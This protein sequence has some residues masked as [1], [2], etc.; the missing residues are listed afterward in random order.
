[1]YEKLMII[2]E[3]I[4]CCSTGVSL[5]DVNS[6]SKVKIIF[7]SLRFGTFGTTKRP[8]TIRICL[9]SVVVA[10]FVVHRPSSLGSVPRQVVYHRE[11]TLH[12]SLVKSLVNVAF[13]L[14]LVS[15]FVFQI[16]SISKYTICF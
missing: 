7:L 11:N 5:I 14:N 2:S 4:A 10:L 16:Y 1:M 15:K 6:S 13:I 8:Y 12:K 9:S 3:F